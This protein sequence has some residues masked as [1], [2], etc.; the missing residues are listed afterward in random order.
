MDNDISKTDN[1][2]PAAD[3]F[4]VTMDYITVNPDSWGDWERLRGRPFRRAVLVDGRGVLVYDNGAVKAA[5]GGLWLAGSPE[6]GITGDNARELGQK[7]RERARQEFLAGLGDAAGVD[8][9]GFGFAA[10]GL[11]AWRDIGRAQYALAADAERGRS[12]TEAAKFIGRAAGFL[13]DDDKGGDN[14]GITIQISGGAAAD[15]LA[16]LARRGPGGSGA[17]G[18]GSSGLVL[19]DGD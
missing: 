13:G 1:I 6:D 16:A 2:L 8:S 7:F 12:S 19:G 3:F 11:K 17:A 9:G 5:D 15:L 10:A 14:G 18:A 4:P